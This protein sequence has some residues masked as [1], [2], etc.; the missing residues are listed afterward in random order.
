MKKKILLDL[1]GV[2]NTY[3]GKYN[4][5]FI[6]PIREDTVEFIKELSKDYKIVIFTSR[7]LF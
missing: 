3:K 5:K 1:D 6:S 4:P 7:N 2:L